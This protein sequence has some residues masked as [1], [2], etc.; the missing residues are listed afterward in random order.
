MH[1]MP[2]A[3]PIRRLP[4]PFVLGVDADP[5]RPRRCC[6]IKGTGRFRR[7]ALSAHRR[8][9]GRGDAAVSARDG[10]AGGQPRGFPDGDD[11][12]GA[13]THRGVPGHG[14]RL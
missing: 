4:G 8:R 1:W 2:A 11:R 3:P 6:W 9:S 12:L 10:R 5:P 14:T 13:G 7:R